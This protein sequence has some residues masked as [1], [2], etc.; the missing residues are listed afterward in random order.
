MR[1]AVAGGTG[2]VGRHVTALSRAAGHDVRVLS[3]SHGVDLRT[4]KGVANALEGVDAVIDVT[5]PDT[6]E[7][8]EATAFW[9]DVANTLQ[10]VGTEQGVRH[11]VAL[12]IVGIDKTSFGYYLAKQAHEHAT[13]AGPVPVT[14]QRATQFHELPARLIALT[15]K[16]SQAQVFDVRVQSVAA[17]AVAGVLVKLA[18]Q[19]PIGRAADLA[20]PHQAELVDL[21]RAFVNRRG[22]PVT[23]QPAPMPGVPANALLPQENARIEGPSFDDW[24]ATEDASALE[25]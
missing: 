9:T 3:R 13:T 19:A 15:R 25:T 20:G 4:G 1:I 6:F 10:R 2:T 18:G 14:V 5:H 16:D 21:A 8:P 17:R 23:V 11:I 7:Q 24:L 22:L 12:S